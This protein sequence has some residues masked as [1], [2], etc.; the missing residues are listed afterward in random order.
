M[1]ITRSFYFILAL[2]FYVPL[3][4]QV[5]KQEVTFESAN[6][7]SLSDIILNLNAQEKQTVFGQL[8]IPMDSLNPDKKYPL[9]IG[10]AGSLGWRKH[11]LEYM[12]MYQQDG[13]ATFELNSFKSR[14][15]TSTVGSQDEVTIA[16]I[17]LDAYRALEKLA[18]HPNIDKEKVSIT[19]WSLGGGVSLFSGW[20]PVKNAITTSVSFASHLAF[21][22]PC[23]INPENLAFTQAPIHILIGEKDN[24]T[25]AA[26]CSNLIKKLEGKA[27]IALTTYPESHHSFDSETP[28]TRNEKGYSFKDCLFTLTEDGDVLM[29]YLQL[30]MS[31]P[32][33]QKLGFMFCVEQGVDIGGNPAARKKAFAFAKE[34]MH[35]TLKGASESS[36]AF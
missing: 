27:N 7:F 28:V 14:D 6:P 19:G 32:L 9:I 10:V 36:D 29:N 31:S 13:F 33:L 1:T 17:I 22:P 25:P 23:F 34:F 2:F 35:T 8:S 21:Y 15:I 4:A 18:E 5:V 3:H 30:P 24:W 16:A 12:E 11:H 20:M 26:P